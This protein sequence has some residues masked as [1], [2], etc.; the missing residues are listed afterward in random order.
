ML[1]TN[2]EE[3]SYIQRMG[4]ITLRQI[5]QSGVKYTLV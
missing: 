4:L 3:V 1:E 2:I 5:P